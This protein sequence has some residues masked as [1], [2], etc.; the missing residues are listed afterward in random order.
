MES[1]G[2]IWIPYGIGSANLRYLVSHET[3]HQWFYS[4]VGNDQARQPFADEAAADFL[5]REITGTRR[6]STLLDRRCSIDTIYSY[7]ERVL[8]RD[9]LHPGRQP[10]QRGAPADGLDGVLGGDAASTSPPTD[11]GCGSTSSCCRPLDDGTPVDLV[12]PVRAPI[13]AVSD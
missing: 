4:L 10:H 1:P 9:R 11:T 6:G 8:L 7:F 13:P 12:E 3:A 5:A 2:L